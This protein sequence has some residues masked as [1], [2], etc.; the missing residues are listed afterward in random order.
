MDLA[1]NLNEGRVSVVL[2]AAAQ[3]RDLAFAPPSPLEYQN[4][5]SVVLAR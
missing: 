1:F 3:I 2:R 5:R 4:G